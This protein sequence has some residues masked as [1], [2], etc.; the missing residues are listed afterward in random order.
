MFFEV[1]G[2][3]GVGGDSVSEV[4]DQVGVFVGTDGE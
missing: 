2:F 1:I 4:E 3:E